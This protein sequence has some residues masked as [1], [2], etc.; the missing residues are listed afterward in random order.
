MNLESKVVLLDTVFV[1]EVDEETILLDTST[2]E[3]FSL[4][5]V[6]TIFY[7]FLEEE[8]DLKVIV[9]EL[10]KHFSTKESTIEIDLL[11]FLKALEE[12][13]LVDFLN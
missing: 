8:Q 6:G 13:G 10:A 4:D 11:A 1:Q 5:E 9:K 3:Y 2:Q 12:K 7:H